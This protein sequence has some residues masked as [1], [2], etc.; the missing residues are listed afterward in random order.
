MLSTSFAMRA[1]KMA[2]T[3]KGGNYK[4]LPYRYV[5]KTSLTNIETPDIG[6]TNST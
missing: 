3:G 5:H 2:G 1:K 6:S 4:P